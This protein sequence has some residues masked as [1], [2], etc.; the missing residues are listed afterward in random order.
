MQEEQLEQPSQETARPPSAE[1]S[2]EIEGRIQRAELDRQIA[3]SAREVAA[4]QRLASEQQRQTTTKIREALLEA[5]E[6]PEE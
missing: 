3:Q 4:V 1:T 5:Y 6:A 2:R